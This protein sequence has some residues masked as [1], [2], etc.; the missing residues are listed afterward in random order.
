MY[1]S[2]FKVGKSDSH[3]AVTGEIEEKEQSYIWQTQ[4]QWTQ[5]DS[6][7]KDHLLLKPRINIKIEI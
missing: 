2:N 4:H 1:C 3:Y 7:S 6:Y 5:T